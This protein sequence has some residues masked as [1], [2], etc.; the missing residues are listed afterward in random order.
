MWALTFHGRCEYLGPGRR[1]QRV[2]PRAGTLRGASAVPRRPVSVRGGLR[3]WGGWAKG[4]RRRAAG[5][6]GSG[7]TPPLRPRGGEETQGVGGARA[8][9]P[10]PRGAGAT[11]SVRRAPDSALVSRR[12]ASAAVQGAG[13]GARRAGRPCTAAPAARA[14]RPDREGAV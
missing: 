11:G 3:R 12:R 1:V 14:A 6:R 2:P 10:R 9:S 7:L 5:R 8:G 13:V 4:R